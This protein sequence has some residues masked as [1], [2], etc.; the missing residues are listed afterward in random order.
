ML[1]KTGNGLNKKQICNFTIQTILNHY[2]INLN[3][4][5]VDWDYHNF[6]LVVAGDGALWIK[7]MASR[8]G[9]YYILDKYHAFNYLWNSFVRVPGEKKRISWLNKICW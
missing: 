9:C 3:I 2:D 1:F 8:L 4:L 7:A 5:G 6:I